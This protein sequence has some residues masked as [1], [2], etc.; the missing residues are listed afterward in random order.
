MANNIDDLVRQSKYIIRGTIQKLN[1]ATMS[2]ISD[3]TNTVVARVDEVLQAPKTLDDYTGR[4]ITIQLSTSR[5]VKVGQ[6]A[7]FFTNSW[8]Y[9]ESIAV[10]EVGRVAARKDLTGLRKQIADADQRIADQ[11]LQTRIDLAE[12]IIVGKVFEA[13]PVQ[14]EGQRG[15]ITEHDPD[16]WEAEIEIESVEKGQFPETR[17]I[18]LFP[19]STDEMWID[20]PKFHVNQE[21]IWILQRDQKVKGLPVLRIPGYTAL[22]PL[23]FQPKDQLEYIRMLIKRS[24]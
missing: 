3:T 4:D 9:G 6:Q 15:P 11:A 5:G 17:I 1:A 10:L 22:D 20:S 14:K 24:R 8:L 13:R 7:V 2:A 12:L 18:E 16:W 21:G 23:D 19:H